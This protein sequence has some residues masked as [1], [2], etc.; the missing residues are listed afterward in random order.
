MTLEVEPM[1]LPRLKWILVGL[2]CPATTPDRPRNANK[3]WLLQD[4]WGS[5]P[6]T[7]NGFFL[8]VISSSHHTYSTFS[9]SAHIFPFTTF[10][11][12]IFSS[13]SPSHLLLST[14]QVKHIVI[15]QEKLGNV[16]KQEIGNFSLSWFLKKNWLY[17]YKTFVQ[18]N[19]NFSCN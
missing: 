7:E 9:F 15:F 10:L 8:K 17:P 19:I 18:E 3:Q 13:L 2:D 14:L 5:Q 6:S 12:F 4:K 1:W 16:W 11:T